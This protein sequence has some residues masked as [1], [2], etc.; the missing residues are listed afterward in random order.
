MNVQLP[1]ANAPVYKDYA[2]IGAKKN[3]VNDEKP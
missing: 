3:F 1:G 2:P